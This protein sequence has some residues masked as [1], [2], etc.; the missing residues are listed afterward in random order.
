MEEQYVMAADI[1][2]LVFGSAVFGGLAVAVA[3]ESRP[4]SAL[5][6][7]FA[8]AMGLLAVLSMVVEA[9]RHLAVS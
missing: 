2:W 4:G 7:G 8:I 5:V 1:L 6:T 3:S 9:T